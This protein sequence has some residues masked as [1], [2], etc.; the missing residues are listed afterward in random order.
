M[1]FIRKAILVTTEEGAIK[2]G[3]MGRTNNTGHR[4]PPTKFGARQ[5]LACAWQP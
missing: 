1:A 2:S 5:F 4:F 3:W